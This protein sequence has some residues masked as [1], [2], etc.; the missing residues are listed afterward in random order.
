MLRALLLIA[1]AAG[2]IRA[3]SVA[4]EINRQLPAWVRFGGEYR[5][6]LESFRGIGFGDAADTHLLNRFRLN[7]K[8]QPAV[9]LKFVAEAQDARIWGNQPGRV[10]SAPPY[11]D[12]LDLRMAYIELGD[13]D[14]K[15]FGLRAGRQELVFGDERLVGRSNWSNVSRTFDAVRATVRIAGWRLDA[16]A[17]SVVPARDGAFDRPVTGNNLHGLYGSS[18]RLVPGATTDAYV[19]WRVAPGTDFR[20]FGTR[21]AG[22]AAGGFDYGI[23]MALQKGTSG[24]RPLRAWAGH[25]QAGHALAA[26]RLAPHIIAEFN[27]ASGDRG[28][29]TRRTF[30]TLYPTPHGKYGLTDQVGWRNVRGLRLGAAMKP[31]RAWTVNANWRSW[32]RAN[33]A[34]G[35]Y[36][37]GGALAVPARNVAA[38]HIG[39]EIELDALWSGKQVQAGAGIGHLFP[40]AFLKSA[41][42]GRS[43]T[44]PYVLLNYTF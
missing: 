14:R 12:T 43:Y 7:L 34:D 26:P 10:A 32:W 6:R 23:E 42:A 17:S 27:Y 2:A 44:Y 18:A 15:N 36:S 41:T 39:Q 30:D 19:L 20:T 38:L 11:R 29:R 33:A 35:V 31:H 13:S 16:F 25:W 24:G 9:W 37:A 28:D 5:A 21:W 1:M 22:T 3:Q 8:V 40:G 4:G